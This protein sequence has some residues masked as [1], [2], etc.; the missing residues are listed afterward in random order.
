MG[1]YSWLW[2]INGVDREGKRHWPDV[3]TD[4]FGCF[5]HGGMRAMAVLP[6]LDLIVSWNGTGIEGRQRENEALGLLVKAISG[7]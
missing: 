2:W 4:A 1:S 5:G 3:P 7:D 6:S